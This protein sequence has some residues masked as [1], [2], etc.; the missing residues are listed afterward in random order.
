MGVMVPATRDIQ[1]TEALVVEF[2]VPATILDFSL[3]VPGTSGE[4][5][6]QGRSRG[7]KGCQPPGK[8]GS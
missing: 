7:M 4:W 8:I 1:L 6:S 5:R 2:M 3:R